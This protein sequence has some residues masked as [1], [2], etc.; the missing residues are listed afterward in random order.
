MFLSLRL[1]IALKDL[2]CFLLAMARG[3]PQTLFA[4]LTSLDN[5]LVSNSFSHISLRSRS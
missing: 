4:A 5:P 1:K 3:V 2:S